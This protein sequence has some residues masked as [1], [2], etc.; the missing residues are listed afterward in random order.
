MR[1]IR[2][3]PRL[4]WMN[5]G[6]SSCG[7]ST[8]VGSGSRCAARRGKLSPMSSGI[9]ASKLVAGFGK[10]SRRP[11][12]RAIATRISGRPTT[13]S[14]LTSS[15]RPVA[16]IRDRLPTSS[17]GITRYVNGSVASSVRACHFQNLRRCTRFVC[18]YSFIV[19][20]SR[21]PHPVEPLPTSGPGTNGRRDI[22]AASDAAARKICCLR[23][24]V[25]L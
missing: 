7:A 15:T 21:L 8:S 16:R 17:D 19:T 25:T 5:Y 22:K 24:F 20:I 9:G 12:K 4:S 6:P 14:S 1:A 10:Q 3:P 23:M 2:H 13:R 18:D 11:I